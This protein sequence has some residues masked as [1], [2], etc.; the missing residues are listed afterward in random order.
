VAHP[1]LSFLFCFCV[2]RPISALQNFLARPLLQQ[3]YFLARPYK[4]PPCTKFYIINDF[5]VQR[6]SYH[7][8]A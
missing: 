2:D 8:K 6:A 7:L 5:S 3:K 4:R 1:V